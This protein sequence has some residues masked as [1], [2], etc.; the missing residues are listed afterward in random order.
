MSSLYIHI[1]PFRSMV[2]YPN[3]SDVIDERQFTCKCN[4]YADNDIVGWVMVYTY[5]DPHKIYRH[6]FTLHLIRF[7]VKWGG[8]HRSFNK[9]FSTPFVVS[10]PSFSS[11]RNFSL[12]SGFSSFASTTSPP[13]TYLPSTQPN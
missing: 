7:T 12:Y 2:S 6:N 9:P 4:A 1:V 5:A 8:N 3:M 11:W 10:L 13:F